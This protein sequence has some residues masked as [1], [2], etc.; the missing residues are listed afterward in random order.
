MAGPAS[1]SCWPSCLSV[2]AHILSSLPAP[3]RHAQKAFKQAGTANRSPA[4]QQATG[5]M[6]A[7]CRQAGKTFAAWIPQARGLASGGVGAHK[8]VAGLGPGGAVRGGPAGIGLQGGDRSWVLV[9]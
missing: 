5:C 1:S 4:T 9:L 8:V 6:A 3:G 2:Q 7:G